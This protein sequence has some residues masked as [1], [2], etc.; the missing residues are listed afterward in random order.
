MARE[1]KQKTEASSS[2]TIKPTDFLAV[3]GTQLQ[4]STVPLILRGLIACVVLPCNAFSPA[5]NDYMISFDNM[6][7][8]F[9]MLIYVNDFY[10]TLLNCIEKS[11]V[12]QNKISHML[13]RILQ[14]HKNNSCIILHTPFGRRY[15][16]KHVAKNNCPF[17]SSLPSQLRLLA[18]P[19][20]Y[21]YFVKRHFIGFRRCLVT[22]SRFN[23]LY[24]LLGGSLAEFIV[25]AS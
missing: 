13:I 22:R 3:S 14:F 1:T 4:F 6:Q 25:P 23:G 2:N 16:C 18:V 10:V 21:H 8:A 5:I 15:E 12:K 19:A 20:V 11:S 7:I 9:S 17:T 24:H